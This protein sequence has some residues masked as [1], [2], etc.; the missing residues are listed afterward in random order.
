MRKIQKQLM[1][2]SLSVIMR[3]FM[4]GKGDIRLIKF[5]ANYLIIVFFFEILSFRRWN[6]G[7]CLGGGEK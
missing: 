1:K 3:L 2:N 6:L 7:M 4:D 5:M